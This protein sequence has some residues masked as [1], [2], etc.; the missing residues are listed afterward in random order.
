MKRWYHTKTE[1]A[2]IF[3][4]LLIYQV[5][6]NNTKN[7]K[8]KQEL[9]EKIRDIEYRI[10][11]CSGYKE[12]HK[13]MISKEYD[14]LYNANYAIFCGINQ[15]KDDQDGKI[16]SGYQLDKLNVDRIKAKRQL[17]QRFLG[18]SPEEIKIDSSGEKIN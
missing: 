15:A 5:K 4:Q 17:S 13:V 1:F 11:K 6:Y 14:D 12:Y 7:N 18:E 3:D 2:E 10:V 9:A 8:I 16:I